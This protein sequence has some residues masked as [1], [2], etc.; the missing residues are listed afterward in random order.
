MTDIDEHLTE[1][2]YDYF[3]LLKENDNSSFGSEADCVNV[4]DKTLQFNEWKLMFRKILILKKAVYV[5]LEKQPEYRFKNFNWFF[6]SYEIRDSADRRYFCSRQLCDKNLL[7]I[8][9]VPPLHPDAKNLSF[10]ID[11]LNFFIKDKSFIERF[12]KMSSSNINDTHDKVR[13]RIKREIEAFRKKH[14]LINVSDEIVMNKIIEENDRINNKQ[15]KLTRYLISKSL[16]DKTKKLKLT[17]NVKKLKRER[18]QIA[19]T[20]LSEKLLLGNKKL[21]INKISVY[22]FSFCLH[23]KGFI[24]PD[25]HIVYDNNSD[26][27]IDSQVFEYG[28]FLNK[29]SMLYFETKPECIDIKNIIDGIRF[30]DHYDYGRIPLEFEL[31][32]KQDKR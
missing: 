14:H 10:I 15:E 9:I 25:I 18:Y 13:E 11:G 4:I 26:C 22:P 12:F 7:F 17:L 20:K 16:K 19:E 6:R 2:Y 3:A 27:L 28:G 23:V 31:F 24:D 1:A 8:E 32:L 21:L 30:I 5:L 29:S